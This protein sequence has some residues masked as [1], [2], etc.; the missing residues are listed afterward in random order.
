MQVSKLGRMYM[1]I[2]A[3]LK[4]AVAMAMLAAMTTASA[5]A[6]QPNGVTREKLA[7]G[8]RVVIIRNAL[9]PVATVELNFMVGGNETP[10]GF[11]GTAHALEHMNFRGCTGMTAD[12]TSA[13]YA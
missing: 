3:G 8:L 9:A 5:S 2:L 1:K 6:P 10:P 13:I 11:P 12:Q 4:T 7:N